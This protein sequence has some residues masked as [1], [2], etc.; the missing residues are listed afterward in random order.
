MHNRFKICFLTSSNE[1][2][3]Q[4][5]SWLAY[6]TPSTLK[7]FIQTNYLIFTTTLI[8]QPSFIT[9]FRSGKTE[10]KKCLVAHPRLHSL[11]KYE[12]EIQIQAIWLQTYM[13]TLCNNTTSI[14]ILTFTFKPEFKFRFSSEFNLEHQYSY[15]PISQN[16]TWKYLTNLITSTDVLTLGTA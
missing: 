7:Q 14:E 3:T 6:Y 9:P 8:R 1:Q 2:K 16:K 12:A 11:N 4:Y 15:D 10:A 5:L 13:H